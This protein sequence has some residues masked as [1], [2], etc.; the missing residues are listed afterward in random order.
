MSGGDSGWRKSGVLFGDNV[1]YDEY[2][3]LKLSRGD[4][5]RFKRQPNWLWVHRF[6]YEVSNGKY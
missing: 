2:V 5:E 1:I 4:L 3:V 6:N